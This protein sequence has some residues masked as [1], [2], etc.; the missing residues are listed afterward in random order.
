M[1]KKSRTDEFDDEF[2]DKE[3]L[4]LDKLHMENIDSWFEIE[5][6]DHID[7]DDSLLEDIYSDECIEYIDNKYNL[8]NL[9]SYWEYINDSLLDTIL[10]GV[11]HNSSSIEFDLCSEYLDLIYKD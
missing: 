6:I 11:T 7:D 5:D 8:L 9:D 10:N 1:L 2:L 4:R 3:L